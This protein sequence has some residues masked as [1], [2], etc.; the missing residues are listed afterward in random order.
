MLKRPSTEDALLVAGRHGLLYIVVV[1]RISSCGLVAAQSPIFWCYSN[2][3]S[4]T[5]SI[6]TGKGRPSTAW[7]DENYGSFRYHVGSAQTRNRGQKHRDDTP[8]SRLRPRWWATHAHVEQHITHN[9]QSIRLY[10]RIHMYFTLT[11]IALFWYHRGFFQVCQHLHV[12]RIL[13]WN[14]MLW[15]LPIL[16]YE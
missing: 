14:P 2:K 8:S 16:L 1:S 15:R 3:M 10:R 5:W 4:S 13:A 7:Y 6:R 12:Y 9:K 11:H